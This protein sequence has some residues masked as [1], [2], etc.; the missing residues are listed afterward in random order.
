[1][2]K[3]GNY[4]FFLLFALI[5]FTAIYAQ[6]GTAGEPVRYIGGVTIDPSVHEGRL[7]WAIGTESIQVMRANRKFGGI[8]TDTGW[9]YNHAPNLA[10][11]NNKFYLQYLSNPVD[12]HIA[13]GQTLLV[14]SADG[15][16]WSNPV[17]I[18]HPTKRHPV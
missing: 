9:T 7:R 11:W 3:A 8:D 4:T 6:T 1:M 13:P 17:I 15:R 16:L 14:T 10:Y 2:L 18:F 5:H 12:E